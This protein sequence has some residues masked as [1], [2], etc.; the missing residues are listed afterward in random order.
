MARGGVLPALVAPGQKGSLF[1]VAVELGVAPPI[2]VVP[3]SFGGGAAATCRS[4]RMSCLAASGTAATLGWGRGDD[5]APAGVVG[6]AEPGS[7]DAAAVAGCTQPH[8]AGGASP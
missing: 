6:C 5:D 4:A 8:R 2:R 3:C 1:T 7:A